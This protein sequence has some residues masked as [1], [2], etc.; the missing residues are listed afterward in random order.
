[1]SK[2]ETFFVR[3]LLMVWVSIPLNG[4]I[5]V[6]L[7]V[8]VESNAKQT[9]LYRNGTVGCEP[10][11]IIPLE[12]MALSAPDAAKCTAAIQQ[13]YAEYPSKRFFARQNLR[14]QQSYHYETIK[15]GCVLY[16]N[17]PESYSEMLLRNGLALID[18][19]F[20]NVEWNGRLKWALAGGERAKRGLHGTQIRAS[21]I[22]EEK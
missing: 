2:N 16:A 3:F 14:L 4:D 18:P 6:G 13:Y 19:K 17:G 12:K 10:F 7:L 1:M 5:T 8:G 21:C 20:D 9:L 11:G 15:E 22:P